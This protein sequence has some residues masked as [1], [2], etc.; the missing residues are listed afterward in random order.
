MCWV[1]WIA[2][3]EHPQFRGYTLER[4]HQ[5]QNFTNPPRDRWFTTHFNAL[6]QQIVREPGCF[7]N[8]PRHNQGLITTDECPE[9]N[10]NDPA[11]CP[12]YIGDGRSLGH[13][14]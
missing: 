6:P 12:C 4:C 7:M 9:A 2:C 10:P 14:H 13:G 3:I 8:A 11:P 1:T 5:A